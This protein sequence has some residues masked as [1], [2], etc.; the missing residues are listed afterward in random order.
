MVVVESNSRLQDTFRDALKRYGYRV[1]MISDPQRALARFDDPANP[2]DGI[3]L[4]TGELRETAVDAFIEFASGEQ[5]GKIPAVLLLNEKHQDW[6]KRVQPH[7]A[8][9]RVA[10]PLPVKLKEVRDV[11]FRLVPPVQTAK[12]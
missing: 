7:L 3:V 8:D 10:V 5:T 9:H 6:R 11:L 4:S 1:L 12:T 2:M